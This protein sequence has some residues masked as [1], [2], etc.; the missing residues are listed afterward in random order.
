MRNARYHVGFTFDGDSRIIQI[1]K[2]LSMKFV[3]NAS[4]TLEWFRSNLSVGN[5]QLLQTE[6]TGIEFV[7]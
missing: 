1:T 3:R 2:I 6:R 7:K 4:S 5:I